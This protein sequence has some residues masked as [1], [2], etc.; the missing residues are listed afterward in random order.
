MLQEALAAVRDLNGYH[1]KDQILR[2]SF[3]PDSHDTE[4]THRARPRYYIFTL[5]RKLVRKRKKRSKNEV[6]Y[7][8][9][10]FFN[11]HFESFWVWKSW[12][13]W[14]PPAYAGASVSSRCNYR[15]R[16]LHSQTDHAV[17]GNLL[18]ID[19]GTRDGRGPGPGTWKIL[20]WNPGSEPGQKMSK[21][22]TWPGIFQK[23]FEIFLM[24]YFFLF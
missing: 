17:K 15:K 23:F 18:Y 14:Y 9:L 5:L 16:G 7:P 12:G 1:L 10:L 21:P 8:T 13:A 4:R 3:L 20:K 6:Y 22:G 19:S 24:K 2:C 11:Q